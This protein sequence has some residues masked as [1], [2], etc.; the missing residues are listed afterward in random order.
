MKRYSK[1]GILLIAFSVLFLGVA[2]VAIARHFWRGETLPAVRAEKRWGNEN[3][4]PVKFKSASISERAR[5]AASLLKL[6]KRYIGIDRS[7]IRA[8]LGDFDGY[9]FSDMFPTYMIEEGKDQSEDSWQIVFLLDRNE[10]VSEIIIHKNC[11]DK[12]F[13]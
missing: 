5:M 11:C 6:Q 10:K 12:N 9:Y 4:D 3:F 7:D 13:K 1:F 8:R 2:S